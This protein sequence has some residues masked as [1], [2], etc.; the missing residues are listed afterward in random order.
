MTLKMVYY[1][2]PRLREVSQPVGREHLAEL[3]AQAPDMFAVMYRHRG[4]GLAGPQVG[5][6]RRILV[7][8]ITGDR[9]Q[10]DQERIFINPEVTKKS[11]TMQE[12]EGCLSLPGL[13]AR[14]RRSSNV[15]V[16]FNDIEG[17]MWEMEC[18]G[19]YAKLFQHEIDHLDGVLMIDK[20]TA[21]DLKQ[22]KPLLK[23]MEDDF[24]AKRE[25]RLR[26]DRDADLAVPK[27]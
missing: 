4:I 11:G 2:D 9:Q 7:A 21:A 16:A 17:A 12:E 27:P 1:P 3:A 13:N 22:F 23:E 8:N 19:L 24:R 15:I 26:R 14:I 6:Q 20:M 18:E 25:P 5:I 10:K